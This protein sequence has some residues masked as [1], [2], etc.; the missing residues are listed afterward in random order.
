[1]SL[2]ALTENLRLAIM[3]DGG[4]A[5]HAAQMAQKAAKR[6]D[7][8]ALSYWRNVLSNAKKSID[9]AAGHPGGAHG[10]GAAGSGH[11]P[12]HAIPT[13]PAKKM[14]F[15]D[16]LTS[17]KN[18]VASAG[19]KAVHAVG[20]AATAIKGIPAASAKLV[21]DSQYRKDTAHAMAAGIKKVSAKVVM[22]VV[23]EVA[24]VIKAGV[25]VGKAA[26]GKKLTD[27]DKHVL[28]AGAKALATTLIGT[29]A[30]GGLAHVTA[31]ALA[32][33]FAAETAIKSFGKAAIM[34]SD[35]GSES[36]ASTTQWAKSIISGIEKGFASLASMSDDELT[37]LLKK[38]HS[39]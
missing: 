7:R 3:E 15:R 5:A 24:E 9:T 39:A 35:D 11:N 37:E 30:L 16:R 6:G 26:S 31:E 28:K 25:V 2:R 14:S 12:A 4:G 34:A 19:S 20:K 33:H 17:L 8:G 27:A 13:A 18:A 29:V 22:H 1:M 10:A 23:D 32:T 21:T 36:K 38:A